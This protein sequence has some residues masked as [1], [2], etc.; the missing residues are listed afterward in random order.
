[1][2]TEENTILEVINVNKF[3]PGV[4]ALEN[5][6]FSLRSG[7]VHALLGENGAGKSTLIK[8]LAG[9]YSLDSG[10]ILLDGK[11]VDITNV[12]D[13]EKLGISVIY[14][15]LVL[16]QNMTVAENIY[17]GREPSN[18]IGILNYKK[19][20]KDAQAIL[21]S[22]GTAIRANAKVSSLSI[23]HK[24]VVEIAKALSVDSR[25][26]VMDEPTASLSQEEVDRLFETIATLKSHG[27]AII[28]ISHRMEELFKI[29]DRVTILR[30]GKYIDTREIKSTNHEELVKLMV[31]RELVSYYTRNA[32]KTDEK[33]LEIQNI[34]TDKIKNISMHVNKG[35][36]VGI[37]GLIGAG[38]TEFANAVFGIDQI[39]S[40]KILLEGKEVKIGGPIDAI[41]QGIV[42]VPESRKDQGL[43]LIQSVMFNITICVLDKF[44]KRAFRV[45]KK[46]EK[47]IVS[48][49]VSKLKIK[50]SS[51]RQH[52]INLSGGNQQKIVL[53]KWLA[54]KP[55]VLILDEP[56]R[57]IDV[58]AKAEI[59]AIMNDLAKLGNGIIM[60]SSELPEIMNMSDK[61]YV[62][63][64]GEIKACFNRNEISQEDIISA[65][66]GVE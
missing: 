19:M 34:S 27:V 31:G 13:S 25:I 55:K 3:F 50:A 20:R 26:I 43:I 53:A 42:L 11:K 57:G 23:A 28:Y 51:G 59:Y 46:T 52:A 61:V 8:I 16:S 9:V 66:I 36:I 21:N 58:G 54:T 35:E 47:S 45:N 24:Q 48:E 63:N 64:H 14:Q 22:L 56:T 49:F 6:N 29:A 32:N 10:E 38:R 60:I 2:S 30:D 5:V 7:E 18:A 62:M 44:I 65:A 41:K 12:V 17:M 40:G 33:L 37:S 15:E 1:M 4:H 39:I